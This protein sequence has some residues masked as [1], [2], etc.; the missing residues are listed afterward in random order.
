MIWDTKCHTVKH[1]LTSKFFNVVQLK[2]LRWVC[3]NC[4]VEKWT[5][6]FTSLSLWCV[7]I[8]EELSSRKTSRLCC[9][10]NNNSH[11]HCS[12]KWGCF[13]S[14]SGCSG[15]NVVS[16]SHVTLQVKAELVRNSPLKR[17]ANL[18]KGTA[19]FQMLYFASHLCSPTY[20]PSWSNG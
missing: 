4:W 13:V 9:F 20:P 3:F 16:C 8:M 7:K 1:N 15:E 2:N 18:H 14:L 17:K 11:S 19:I 5:S 6:E 12:L 10:G